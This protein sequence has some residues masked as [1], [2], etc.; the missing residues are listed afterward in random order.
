MNHLSVQI[1]KDEM[2]PCFVHIRLSEE[3][4]RRYVNIGNL[5]LDNYA[6]AVK[7]NPLAYFEQRHEFFSD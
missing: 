6:L 2:Q 4:A 1:S 3:D 7:I 5:Y